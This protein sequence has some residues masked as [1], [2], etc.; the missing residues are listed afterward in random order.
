MS[1]V[2]DHKGLIDRK[3]ARFGH[4]DGDDDDP[5]CGLRDE[6]QYRPNQK[7]EEVGTSRIVEKGLDPVGLGDGR[8]PG[9]QHV[10]TEKEERYAEERSQHMTK[11]F[12]PF[13]GVADS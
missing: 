4:G 1:P 6:G 2:D 9:S 5:Q 8:R 11:L 10:Q 7:G 3:E 13:K 12:R